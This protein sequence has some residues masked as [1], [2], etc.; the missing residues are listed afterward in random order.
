MLLDFLDNLLVIV[1]VDLLFVDLHDAIPLFQACQICW[2]V[3][4]HFANELTGLALLRMQ[5]EAIA[6]EIGPDLQVA[7]TGLAGRVGNCRRGKKTENIC[8]HT[9]L[10]RK[11]K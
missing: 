5:I 8:M 11:S 1:L 2:R 6:S 4:V 10:K 7:L 3:G 9:K